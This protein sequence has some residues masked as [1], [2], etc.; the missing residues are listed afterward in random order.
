[1]TYLDDLVELPLV[2]SQVANVV[3]EDRAI[4]EEVSPNVSS[5]I[6]QLSNYATTYWS[7]WTFGNHL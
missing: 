7:M 6:T 4:G 1:M 2:E 3:A 5:I